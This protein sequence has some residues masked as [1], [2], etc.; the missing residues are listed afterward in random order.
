MRGFEVV[1]VLKSQKRNQGVDVFRGIAILAVVLYHFNG[2]L[3]FGYLGVDLF[4]VVSG[5]LVGGLLTKEFFA[6]GR[7]H[8]FRFIL[9]RG[10]KIWPSYYVFFLLGSILAYFFYRNSHPDQ[11]IPLWDMKRYLLFYQNYTGLPFHWSFD[12]V[13]SLCVEEHFYIL[14]PLMFLFIQ[15][16]VAEKQRKIMVYSLVVAT[17]FA[18]VGFKALSWY[19]TDGKDTYSATHNR[20][21]GLAWGVLLNLII[22]DHGHRI[23][24]YPYLKGI[25]L[26]GLMFFLVVIYI[27]SVFNSELYNRVFLPSLVPIAYFLMLM[28][29]Y[30]MDF[31]RW[32]PVRFI[33]YYSYNWYLW[34]PVFVYFIYD[35]FGYTPLGLL[36]YLVLSFSISVIMTISVEEFFLNR[37]EKILNKWFS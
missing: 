1:R 16:F 21:D 12:H 31:S 26:I 6:N 8:F 34:Y 33:A 20:L 2:S 28:A 5:L 7:I 37:R 24:S 4:F 9:Q 18:G 19:F 27:S 15:R 17:I 14:L 35:N 22:Y 36:I 11:I 25:F 10:F 29:V 30:F 3:P 23:K 32:L 13:W